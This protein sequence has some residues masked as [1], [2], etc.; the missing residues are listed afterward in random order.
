MVVV[1]PRTKADAVEASLREAGESPWQLG[2][3]D[4]RQGQDGVRFIGSL[5]R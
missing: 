1:V 4:L 2:R 3:L 5:A